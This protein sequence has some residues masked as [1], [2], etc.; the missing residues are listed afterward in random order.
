M[1]TQSFSWLHLTDFHFGLDGQKCLWPN[2]REPFLADLTELHKQTGPWQAVLFSGD[3]VQQGKS[4][5]FKEVQKE[6]LD[7]LWEKLAELGSGDAVLLAVPGNHDLCRP[8]NGSGAV[9]MLLL[10]GGFSNVSE[11][12][13]K[14]PASEY[15]SVIND[16]F[17]SYTGWWKSAA[18]RAKELTTGILPGDFACTL[19]CGEQRIGIVGLNTAFLQLQGGDYKGKLVWDTRQLQAVC[20]GA[21]DDWLKRHSLCLLLTHQGPDWLTP[22]A[23]KHGESEIAPAG[24]FAAHLFG[25]MHETSIQY[26]RTG[27][28]PNAVRLCQGCSVFGMEMF[29]EPPTMTR[30]HGY[31]AGKI[32]FQQGKA[33]LRIWPRIATNKTGPW[34]F[35]PDYEHGHLESDHG[36][37]AETLTIRSL[38][39]TANSAPSSPEPIAPMASP[40]PVLTA[41]PAAPTDPASRGHYGLDTALQECS[42]RL[43]Q[44]H[45]LAVFGM[46]GVGKSILVDELRQLQEWRDRRLIQISAREDSGLIDFYSQLAP[47]LG[48]HD[49]RPRPPAGDTPAKIAEALYK[50]APAAAPFFLHV[51]RA[52][53]WFIHGHWRDAALACLL[54][55]LVHVY[56]ESLIVLETR[57]QPEADLS[58]YEATGLPKKSL[59]EYLSHPPGL[60]SGWTLNSDQ[61]QYLFTRLGGGHGQ[62]AHCYGLDLL[63]RL[64]AAKA[65]SPYKVLKQYPDDYVD[66]LYEKLFRDLYENVLA[67]EEREMLFA[68]SLYRDGLHYSHL[69]RLE[70]ALPAKAAG[71]ALVRRR[72]LTENNEWLHLHDLAAEQARKLAPAPG[73]IQTLHRLIAGLWLDDLRGHTTLVEANIR[74]ALEA[75]YHLEE[76]GQGERVTEI[77]PTLFGRRPQ[78]TIKALWRMNDRFFSA[79]DDEKV[80]LT[81]EYLLKIAPEDHRAM[82]FLGECRRRLFSDM[83]PEALSLFRLATRLDPGFPQ[84]W[85]DYGN[86]A[87]AN[88]DEAMLAEFLAEIVEAPERARNDYVIAIL[89]SALE[90]VGRDDEAAKLRQEKITT[91]SRDAAFYADHAKWLL[92]KKSDAEEALKVL[93]LAQQR[94]CANAVT[95]TIRVRALQQ[96]R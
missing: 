23:R 92:D 79:Q 28:N 58:V 56:P 29:G 53:L 35:I 82:R 89:A 87:I 41:T 67:T 91:G 18:H 94:G 54:E 48:I 71:D 43:R 4:D 42:S 36:T 78:E 93:E 25:H 57:E 15:R 6:V 95:D 81:L 86:A 45:L 52:H 74:R 31:T 33:S 22:D 5:E 17:A 44:H 72:L 59:A 49:E 73:R 10:Q 77:A 65:V 3:L 70:Q 75:L 62:G 69:P 80:R 84:Y 26:I 90:A 16:A 34:R 76:G 7:K 9:D 60:N 13:W 85:A 2:L 63:V 14:D 38:K 20:G 68:C 19:A 61:R 12:F 66:T 50:A 51:Q 32:E 30:S 24:R 1:P 27:G 21:V 11:T 96:S 88:G 39:T 8:Q 37:A 64:A 55:G 40:A 47:H 46:A 83:D